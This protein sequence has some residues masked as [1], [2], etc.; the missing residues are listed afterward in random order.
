[1]NNKISAIKHNKDDRRKKKLRFAITSF[2]LQWPS[3][4]S[5]MIYSHVF[6]RAFIAYEIPLLLCRID[7]EDWDDFYGRM[8][9]VWT[10]F[11]LE[12][13]FWFTT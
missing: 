2:R 9:E 13:F 10:F 5:L 8:N 6:H 11:L 12:V 3:L 7:T 1:M 4:M